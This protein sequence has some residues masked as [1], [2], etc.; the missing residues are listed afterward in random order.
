MSVL[1]IV[2]AAKQFNVTRP[3]IYRSIKRG[4][5]TT[6][7]SDDGVQL[8]Q[9]QDMI[10]LFDN[11]PKKAVL[12]DV[13]SR[14]SDTD[15]KLVK[16]LEE[17]LKKAEDDKAFLKQQINDLRKDFDEYKLRIEHQ[18]IVDPKTDVTS[19]DHAQK[20]ESLQVEHAIKSPKEQ[21]DSELG[22][23]GAQNEPSKKGLL[24]R[25]LGE[26]FR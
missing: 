26:F 25:F 22:K 8:V 9:V 2:E 11:M 18:S 7:L 15:L 12:K 13:R 19:N 17:Q 4:E 24:R 1:T 16:L 23:H 10:R 20:T 5:L 6:T 3:R 14:V 21:H